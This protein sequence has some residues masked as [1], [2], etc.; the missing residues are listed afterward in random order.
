MSENY[1][2]PEEG[3]LLS[4][5]PLRSESNKAN[6]LDDN[7]KIASSPFIN[8]LNHTPI[9]KIPSKLPG[10]D[11]ENDQQDFVTPD[12]K[13]SDIKAI[14]EALKSLGF[15]DSS[16]SIA[17]LTGKFANIPPENIPAIITS[18]PLISKAIAQDIT[19][20]ITEKRPIIDQ[21]KIL[22][23]S[24]KDLA[25]LEQKGL[26]LN[27]SISLNN[28][29]KT[30]GVD[31][32]VVVA[33]LNRLKD[34]LLGGD[35]TKYIAK[36]KISHSPKT[37]ISDQEFSE[38]NSENTNI[39]QIKKLEKKPAVLDHADSTQSVQ[40]FPNNQDRTRNLGQIDSKDFKESLRPNLFSPKMASPSPEKSANISPEMEFAK[41]TNRIK[42]VDPSNIKHTESIETIY[43]KPFSSDEVPKYSYEQKN[44]ESSTKLSQSANPKKAEVDLP[45]KPIQFEKTISDIKLGDDQPSNLREIL[46]QTDKPRPK[47]EEKED[48]SHIKA[49]EQI[50]SKQIPFDNLRYQ[51]IFQ[52]QL[53]FEAEVISQ[54]EKPAQDLP[55]TEQN[56]W[57]T[58]AF[59]Q[60]TTN[61]LPKDPAYPQD[62]SQ[63]PQINQNSIDKNIVSLDKES[64]RIIQTN[65]IQT[66]SIKK[67]KS[68]TQITSGE[69]DTELN[70]KSQKP[71]STNSS[72]I[73]QKEDI[74][75]FESNESS[76]Q[77]SKSAIDNASLISD[78][79]EKIAQ[80]ME[81]LVQRGG[82]NAA[83][84]LQ[85]NG[86][87]IS[88]AVG[89]SG[90][91]VNIKLFSEEKDLLDAFKED[92]LALDN[93]LAHHNLELAQVDVVKNFDEKSWT[94]HLGE[95]R[96]NFNE[97]FNSSNNSSGFDFYDQ[98]N[99]H[100][101]TQELIS[102]LKS[103][104]SIA[105]QYVGRSLTSQKIAVLA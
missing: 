29:F 13:K 103:L 94:T 32:Q 72:L 104:K 65:P 39:S 47:L 87:K 1:F 40:K 28:L 7:K 59:T 64:K 9:K 11:L 24:D 31:P 37:Q 18:D 36:A 97:Q 16:Q 62:N 89:L 34:N 10:I 21:L 99:N 73:L 49:Y 44:F 53:K 17:L 25:K 105:N 70:L 45:L 42:I 100:S 71:A 26:N 92:I 2:S 85:H 98:R 41:N 61:D 56:E 4:P 5:S 57:I 51:D 80:Q 84:H 96:N 23:V 15:V 22:Q 75:F 6:S 67:D 50:V 38:E 79:Q 63:T 66:L 95:N 69:E 14:A 58:E 48:G 88:V 27:Q 86:S 91:R 81:F 82:G 35:I 76:H 8:Q 3:E 102:P 19:E 77:V 60:L 101:R 20:F 90:D 46:N 93:A 74:S 12:Y 54:K 43:K 33:E 30:L 52:K 78:I 55:S 68:K 83:I